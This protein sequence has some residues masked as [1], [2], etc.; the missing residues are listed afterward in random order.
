MSRQVDLRLISKTIIISY[1]RPVSRDDG[2]LVGNTFPGRDVMYF[3]KTNTM[4]EIASG[5]ID[6]YRIDPK[7]I[8]GQ[9]IN[10]LQRGSLKKKHYQSPRT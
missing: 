5:V 10:G 9:E 1:H 4:A 8:F 3:D 6:L 7:P 2:F